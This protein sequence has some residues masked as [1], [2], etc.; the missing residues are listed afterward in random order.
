MRSISASFMLLLIST[1]A[2][3]CANC[4]RA[5]MVSPLMEGVE[6]RELCQTAKRVAAD[7]EGHSTAAQFGQPRRLS[8]D[9]ESA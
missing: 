9:G 8:G 4:D 5:A 2:Y 1:T 3:L 7:V 6:Y